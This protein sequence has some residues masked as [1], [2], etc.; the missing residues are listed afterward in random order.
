MKY[1]YR[2]AALLLVAVMLL[3]ACSK[4]DKKTENT[5][6]I[7]YVNKAGT[8]LVTAEYQAKSSD[9]SRLVG[10][11]IEAMRTDTSEVGYVKAIPEFVN[12]TKYE[13]QD[14]IAYVTF[15]SSYSNMEKSAEIL[16]RAAL[17]MTLTQIT[18]IDYVNIYINEQPLMGSDSIPVGSMKA[19]DFVDN[20]GAA[21]NSYQNAVV[22][23][24]Y[25]NETG[26]KLIAYTVEG[27]YSNNVS[28][29]RY[30]VEQL[31][32]G[33]DTKGMYR[34][35]PDSVKLVSITTKDGICYVNFSKEFLTDSLDVSDEVTIYS[36]VNS[37]SEF[38]YINKVQISVNGETNVM[39]HESISL[40]KE[41]D[42]N[43]DLV[44][45]YVQSETKSSK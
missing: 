41:F 31:M 13:I 5:Y 9:T 45:K 40:E 2:L 17:V 10:E 36:I 43:L 19:S 23:L 8:K 3:G 35:I 20:S 37:L 16:C 4:D 12:I 27:I 26:D 15:D 25:A 32:K 38:S 14:K 1:K 30:V 22:T 18:G 33:P 44:E 7:Y 39:Y 6:D 11:L 28:M 21:I 24:Y 42:R 29:E 34:T